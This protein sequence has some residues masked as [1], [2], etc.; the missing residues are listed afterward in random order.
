M[1]VRLAIP[2]LILTL[3]V[4]FAGCT[5][6][7]F[8]S[9]GK[10]CSI[11]GNCD[12]Y[13]G[14]QQI[15]DMIVIQEVTVVPMANNQVSPGSELEVMVVLKNMNDD[16]PVTVTWLGISDANIFTCE[17]CELESEVTIS[18][19][20]ERPFSF[21]IKAP[22]NL[23][24]MAREGNIE[25]AATYEYTSAY[26]ATISYTSLDV[27]KKYLETGGSVPI[28]INLVNSD[29][30]IN[31]GVEFVNMEQPVVV[32]DD[33]SDDETSGAVQMNFQITNVGNGQLRL[34]ENETL[35]V[36]FE[37]DYGEFS[38]CSEEFGGED[39]SGNSVSNSEEIYIYGRVPKKYYLSFNS[40]LEESDFS[41][42]DVITTKL[43]ITAEDYKYRTNI[44]KKI[45]VSPEAA[46]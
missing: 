15:T 14:P 1:G 12:V 31:F 45:V 46:I 41:D 37:D 17:E 33:N 25:V 44:S 7:E 16:S 9:S 10:Y 32:R 20:H 26:W 21:T 34:I 24:S 28:T 30:P 43:V 19:G 22:E 23:G 35:T 6:N 18:P 42:Q 5:G 36:S 29:G 39:C 27:Y 3:F 4:F 8:T 38:V 2:L 40:N 13:E 11:I